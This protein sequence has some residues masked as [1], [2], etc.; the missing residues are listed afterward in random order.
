MLAS[1]LP[2]Y[3]AVNL[4]YFSCF[5]KPLNLRNPKTFNEKI[6]V[7]LLK[8]SIYAV[9]LTVGKLHCLFMVL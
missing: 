9:T 2:D 6:A 3:V 4:L 1:I 5:R 8:S 7:D